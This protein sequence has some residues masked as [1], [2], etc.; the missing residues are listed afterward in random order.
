M[1]QEEQTT[2]SVT[3]T[4]TSGENHVGAANE[5]KTLT[6]DKAGYDFIRQEEVNFFKAWAGIKTLIIPLSSLVSFEMEG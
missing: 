3:V 6:G 4:Y 1:N 5:S 2:K